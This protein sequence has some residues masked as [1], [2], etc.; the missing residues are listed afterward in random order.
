MKTLGVLGGMGPAATVAFLA[1]VQTLTPAKGD[2]DHIR[3][4]ADINPQVPNRHSQPEA[5]GR[6]LGE[7]A[8]TLA[9]WPALGLSPRGEQS[10]PSVPEVASAA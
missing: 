8:G 2:E 1:R 7:M 6:A 10:S 9:A 4:L 3:V 5:A